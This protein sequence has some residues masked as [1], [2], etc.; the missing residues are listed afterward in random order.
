MPKGIRWSDAGLEA[1]KLYRGK[2]TIPF[3]LVEEQPVALSLPDRRYHTYISGMTGMGKS[4]LMHNLIHHHIMTGDG[5]GVIDPHGSLV[6]KILQQ[7]IPPSRVD[8]VV[9]LKVADEDY[10][11]PSIPCEC[12][13]GWIKRWCF[14]PCCGCLNPSMPAHGARAEWRRPSEPSL[15]YC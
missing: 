8:D 5:V 4:T 3:G 2:N 6:D 10:P 11:I 13:M 7:S 12:Q 1:V 14:I 9:Y 15:N